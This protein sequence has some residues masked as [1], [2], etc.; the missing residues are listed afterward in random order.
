MAESLNRLPAIIRES[1]QLASDHPVTSA[2]RFGTDLDADSFQMI[3]LACA[4]EENFGIDLHDIFLDEIETFADLFTLV[5]N[6][7]GESTHG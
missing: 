1:F 5:E 3:V 6:R 4:L 2:T 7:T